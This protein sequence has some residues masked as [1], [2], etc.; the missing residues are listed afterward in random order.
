MDIVGVTFDGEIE[1]YVAVKA[2]KIS[3]WIDPDDLSLD[4]IFR[5]TIEHQY[6]KDGFRKARDLYVYFQKEDLENISVDSNS[7]KQE[8]EILEKS[9]SDKSKERKLEER[10]SPLEGYIYPILTK[11]VMIEDDGER[12]RIRVSFEDYSI[13]EKTKKRNILLPLRFKKSII[14]FNNAKPM[15]Q[16]TPW[17]YDCLIEPYLVQTLKWNKEEFMPPI[18]SLE[19]WLQIP[20]EL[21]GSLSAVNVQPV[22]HFDQMFLLGKEIAKRFRKV[23]QPRAQEKTLCMNWS[24]SDVSVSD[25]PEEIEVT[26]GLRQFK[27]EADFVKRFEE[28]RKDSILILRDILYKCKIQTVDFEYIISGVSNRYLRKVLEIFNTM[29]FQRNLRPTKENLNLLVPLLEHFR[30]LVY[31]REFFNRYDILRALI[32]CEKSVDLFSDQISS[33]L[34]RIRQVED[35]L[36]P[37]Y[38][39]LMQDFSSLIELT[40]RFSLYDMDEDRSR[41]MDEVLSMIET[42]DHKWGR[43]LTHPDRHILI[44][45]LANWKHIVEKEYEEQVFPF[46]I[47]A[48]IKTKN[49]VFAD[50]IGILIS[51]RSIG[52]GEVQ[53]VQARLL[54]TDDYDIITEKSETQAYLVSGGRPFEPE[55]LIK[56]KDTKKVIVSYEICCKDMLGRTFR[57]RFEDTIDFIEKEILFQKIQNPYIIGEIVRENKMFYGRE[58]LLESIIEYFKGRYQTNPVFLYGQ[59]RTGKTSVLFQLKKKLSDDF[60]PI[61]FTSLEIFGKKSF[62]EDLMEKI[63]KELGFID[64]EIPDIENDPFNG[65]KNEFYAKLT[66]RLEGKKI[67]LMI[68]EYQRIDELIAEGHYDKSVID[69]FKALAEDGEI[70]FILAGFLQPDELKN[71]KWVELMRSFVTKYVSFLSREDAIKLICEPVRNLMEYDRGGIEK[72]ISFSGY[73]PYFVQL[74]CHTMVEHH[75]RDRVNI[76]GYNSV[77]KHLFNYFEKGQNV[78]W[79]IIFNQTREVERRTLFFMSHLMEKKKKKSVHRSEIEQNFME[80]EKRMGKIEKVLHRLERREIIRKSTEHPDHYEFTIDL[81]RHW[82]RWNISQR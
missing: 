35:G 61:F 22:G 19:I 15:T 46:R 8:R 9:Q 81:Y 42:L 70:K 82:I 57:K 62:Y 65:F 26:C 79:D 71:K 74:I 52:R 4:V 7:I 17:S 24:F 3:K 63:K 23:G 44:D 77:T 16:K 54:Q 59:R 80:Y 14:S 49:L 29:V 39:E 60:V 1:G 72:I 69:F 76:I 73:H 27:V 25:P 32:C 41:Y 5:L 50:E 48:A 78:F 30:D 47:E 66:Q 36:D 10:I 55:L 2:F 38:V 31:G 45:I 67:V 56:P 53:D 28:N 64:I 21:Y 51:I 12:K 18:E 13:T 33:K 37:V 34:K 58:E 11:V 68:D 6:R 40:E 43:K 20:K 75:N